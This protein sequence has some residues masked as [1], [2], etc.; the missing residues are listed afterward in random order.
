MHKQQT[1]LE[2][3]QVERSVQL[4]GAD[5]KKVRKEDLIDVLCATLGMLSVAGNLL[6][7]DLRSSKDSVKQI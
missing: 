3:T 5:V 7:T 4:S 6:A 1:V 2:M